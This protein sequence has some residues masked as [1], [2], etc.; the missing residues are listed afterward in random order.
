[1]SFR[2]W[3]MPALLLGLLAGCAETASRPEA[4]APKAAV[5]PELAV[6]SAVRNW[7]AAWQ[8]REVGTYLSAY[9]ADFKPEKGSRAAWEKQRKARIGKAKDIKLTLSNI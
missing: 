8:S 9:A 6:E 7:A 3:V 5:A 4:E 1:M 2:N